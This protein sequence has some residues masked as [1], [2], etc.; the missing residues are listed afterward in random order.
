MEAASVRN[1]CDNKQINKKFKNKHSSRVFDNPYG[2]IVKMGNTYICKI[3]WTYWDCCTCTSATKR[4][5]RCRRR[6]K[7]NKEAKDRIY[8]QYGSIITQNKNSYIARNKKYKKLL[9]QTRWIDTNIDIKA[10]KYMLNN[11]LCPHRDDC[12]FR[13]KIFDLDIPKLLLTTVEVKLMKNLKIIY[14]KYEDNIVYADDIVF[15]VRIDTGA[16]TD[17]FQTAYVKKLMQ[18]IFTKSLFNIMAYIMVF[19]EA[20]TYYCNKQWNEWLKKDNIKCN[21]LSKSERTEIIIKIRKL[22]NYYNLNWKY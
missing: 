16:E 4:R 2:H 14:S 1:F 6:H 7:L 9:P 11:E 15:V 3:C 8:E 21:K 18:Y 20:K 12:K 13:H 22:L 5:L 17:I 10:C 19:V